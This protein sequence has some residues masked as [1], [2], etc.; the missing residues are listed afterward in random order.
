MA[1]NSTIHKIAF[2]IRVSTEEQAENPEGSIRNQEDRLHQAV[3]LKNMDSRFGD[4]AGVYVD[5]ARS[6]KDTNRPE[7]QRLLQAIRKREVTLVMVTELSRLSRSI[8]DFC[9]MWELM[10]ASDC[11][12]SSLRESF[13]T[14][15]AAGEM[16]LYTIANIA[17]F[18]RRQV[19][20]RLAANMLARS[21]RG[22][23]NGGSVPVGYKLIEDKPGFLEIDEPMAEVVRAAFQAFLSHGTLSHAA[24]AMNDQDHALRKQVEGGGGK[25][26]LS[27]FTVDNLQKMLRNKAYIGVRE[28]KVKSEM[29]E[30]KATWS[31]IVEHDVFERVQ[32]ILTANKSRKK[33]HTK[34]RYPYL[35]SGF[36]FC[37][38]CGDHL[39]GKSAHGNSGKVG[40]YEHSW[41]TKRESCLTKKTF[42]CEPHRVLAKKLEPVVME[43]VKRLLFERKFAEELLEEANRLYA[44]DEGN[45]ELEKLKAKFYGINSQTEALTERLSQIPKSVSAVPI[46]KQMERLE[47]NKRG[48][49]SR[50]QEYG[51]KGQ[52]GDKP[53]ELATY[54][55]FANYLRE[56]M[57]TEAD[58][59]V[60]AKIIARLI[61]RVE[62][63]TKSVNIHYYAGQEHF[64]RELGVAQMNAASAPECPRGTL[65]RLGYKFLDFVGLRPRFV[66]WNLCH[67]RI[68]TSSVKFAM[69]A[70][71]RQK[72]RILFGLLGFARRGALASSE[73]NV[74]W[75]YA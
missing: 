34:I 56:I 27:H 65:H 54:E 11:D 35:L 45:S 69:K 62:V 30:A 58:S 8:K 63:G 21:V 32:E 16:V 55:A 44:K 50:I 24:R 46:F 75:V 7:L 10:R 17:Q 61:H 31:A 19:S 41:A 33:P 18:E 51:R 74:A 2:Y 39:S 43:N 15:T 1:K 52:S 12:F 6:G 20:E 60:Q 29:K 38:A 25:M 59:G 57:K 9:E 66:E 3:K 70:V 72:G 4:V 48:I 68:F 22:L 49:E 40:Y 23:Y 64:E 67:A 53:V 13:D 28:Y 26:R 42:T 47:A 5:R 73:W 37:E 36:T 71:A 14:T